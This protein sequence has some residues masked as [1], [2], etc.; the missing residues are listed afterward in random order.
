[1]KKILIIL[2]TTSLISTGYTKEV[3][4]D[5]LIEVLIKVESNGDVYAIG[6]NGRA[7]GCLQI[8]DVVISDVNRIYKTSYTT[9][10]T[11]NRGKSIEI[12]KKY[13]I[14]YGNIYRKK[15]GNSPTAE[16]YA[17]QWNGG[18]EGYK[19]KSTLKYW[20]KVRLYL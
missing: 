16:V 14:Y 1:M 9:S 5:K 6:D 19:Y 17:R 13:L 11:F 2:I 8:W 10:D 12:C 4:L 20:N 15:T 7:K 18:P 3:D